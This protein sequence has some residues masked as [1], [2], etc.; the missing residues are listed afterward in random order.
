MATNIILTTEQKKLIK[1][2][3][4]F[5]R[6]TKWI[7]KYR[8]R[9]KPSEGEKHHIIPKCMGGKDNEANILLLGYREHYIAHYILAK[10]FRHKGLW[11]A[12]T[13]MRRVCSRKSCL[14]EVSR[15]Y[16]SENMSKCNKGKKR[17]D[18]QKKAISILSKGKINVKNSNGDMFR[19]SLNDPRY[20]SGELVFY[21]T[22]T[23]QRESTK[24]KM[25]KNG[26]GGRKL[27]YDPIT[28]ERFF[29]KD[30]ENISGLI[31]G[32]PPEAKEK[33]FLHVRKKG[34]NLTT[35]DCPHCGVSGSGGNMTRYHF[36]NCKQYDQTRDKTKNPR[37][38]SRRR[39]S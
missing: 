22:G 32:Y 3:H 4:F 9:P 36:T 8:N 13:C 21:R 31:Q 25:A 2:E 19:V 27:Y 6:Y 1:S 29:K 17:T 11:F 30:G 14:Y 26:I 24:D 35:V 33:M 10:T 28:R 23:K 37:T 16:I 20:M 15:K 39:T 7:E 12:F 34:R 5:K 18:A 38:G